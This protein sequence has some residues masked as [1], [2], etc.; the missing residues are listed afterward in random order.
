MAVPL[1]DIKRQHAPIREEID[2]AVAKVL[3]HGLFIL[4]PEVKQLEEEI[5]KLCGVKHAIGVASGTDALMLALHA[6]GV[7]P[8]DEVIT[9]AFS[10]FASASVISRLGAKPVFVDID[11]DTYNL[12]PGKLETAI[13]SRTKAIL[14][15]HIFGQC[16]AMDEIV[17]IATRHNIKVVEDAAQAIGTEYKGKK[18][19][20]LGD[21]GCFSFFPTKNLG[22]GGDGGMVVTNNDEL[23]D[24]VRML[25]VHGG[26]F[27]YL[28][29]VIGYNSRLDTLQAAILLAKLPYLTQWTDGRRTNAAYYDKALSGLPLKTPVVSKDARHIYHQYTIAIEKRDDFIEHLKANNISSKVYYPV[30]FHL[31]KCFSDLGYHLGDI[32]NCEQASNTVV[33]LPVFGEM[34]EAERTEVVEVIKSFF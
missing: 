28:H 5:A 20:S 11:I 25:R 29:E 3:D 4:G 1:L 7:G 33:S 31:Q 6:C 23:A 24:M 16:A 17:A 26:K 13:N 14:P 32:P 21:A 30:P 18:A 27:E 22:C 2:A 19:G 10:F 9:S 8:G 34:T 15:I 12:D